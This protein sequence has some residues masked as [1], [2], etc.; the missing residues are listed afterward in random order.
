MAL[1]ATMPNTQGGMSAGSVRA[2]TGTTMS[3]R[4]VSRKPF[5]LI[6]STCGA[7]VS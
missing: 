3:L 5:R 7:L 2:L 4:P 6:A 1:A